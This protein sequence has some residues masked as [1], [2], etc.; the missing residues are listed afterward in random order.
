MQ[1][2]KVIIF[3]VA[4]WLTFLLYN[5]VAMAQDSP[6]EADLQFSIIKT[7]TFNFI[8]IISFYCVYFFIVPR[9]LL[10]RKN[11][12]LFLGLMLV[13]VFLVTLALVGHGKFIDWLGDTDEIYPE[14]RANW[15]MYTYYPLLFG[16]VGM[17]M[18]LSEQWDKNKSRHM[19]LEQQVT[20]SEIA[21][22]KHQLN[23]H[24]IFNMLNS[25]YSLLRRKD[26]RAE[27]SLLKLSDLI[28]VVLKN[29]NAQRIVLKEEIK[30]LEDF[31]DLQK[32][33]M[34]RQ[35]PIVF[36][37]QVPDDTIEIAPLIL[38]TFL[39]NAFK[40]GDLSDPD[41][42][43]TILLETNAADL[44]YTIRNKISDK[45]KD[46]SSGIGLNNL[47]RRLSLIYGNNCIMS[48]EIKNNIYEASL[49][50]RYA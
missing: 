6:G 44:T 13:Q 9:S 10:L 27:E 30:Y 20:Y 29:S 16:F 22:L 35:D 43:V 47:K 42:P 3:H 50:I 14:R 48:H 39:E 36:N 45:E 41:M 49:K 34:V 37:K 40:H 11:V 2:K 5:V 46:E 33:R 32:L 1:N 4:G 7:L 21:L 17:G 12:W 31:I 18:R 24:F 15:L 28:R 38:V 23:S 25:I 19:Q 26:A 8:I